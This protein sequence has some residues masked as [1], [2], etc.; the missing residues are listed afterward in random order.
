MVNRPHA[1]ALFL[2]PPFCRWYPCCCQLLEVSAPVYRRPE[3]IARSRRLYIRVNPTFAVGTSETAVDFRRWCPISPPLF[4][5]AAFRP[6]LLRCRLSASHVSWSR[7]VMGFG[8][9]YRWFPNNFWD[10][11]T[12]EEL[13]PRIGH[14]EVYLWNE[15]PRSISGNR[16]L[17]PAYI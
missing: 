16:L 5:N 2:I 9:D 10:I 1:S 13:R 4:C 15:R 12:F 11:Q 17:E 14:D 6:Y 8:V 3:N 7:W